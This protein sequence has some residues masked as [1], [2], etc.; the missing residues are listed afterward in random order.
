M[1]LFDV[2]LSA[3]KTTER[4]GIDKHFR[5]KKNPQVQ[6][7]SYVPNSRALTFNATKTRT[8]LRR[9]P[10]ETT[11]LCQDRTCGATDVV[12]HPH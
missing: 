10:K 6:A 2:D 3:L 1:E 7:A 11:N 12:H 9:R 8:S 4:R 5:I